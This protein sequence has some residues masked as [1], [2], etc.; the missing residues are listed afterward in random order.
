MKKALLFILGIV[1]CQYICAAMYMTGSA[2]GSTSIDKAIQMTA[3]GCTYTWFGTLKKGTLNFIT[4]KSESAS[5]YVATE[6]KESVELNKRM[7][8]DYSST[9][10]T[11]A[12]SFSAGEYTLV[13]DA[14]NN[15]LLVT[16][17]PGQ[18]GG[19]TTSPSLYLI[20][21]STSAGWNNDQ[22][23]MMDNN[24]DTYTY[25]GTFKN[26]ELKFLTKLGSW[27]PCYVATSAN[28]KVTV[29]TTYNLAYRNGD[30]GAADNKFIMPAGEYTITITL[31]AA[32]HKGTMV[33]TSGDTPID[34]DEPDDPDK[35]DYPTTGLQIVG[36]FSEWK[37]IA[38]T[39]LGGGIYTY[40]GNFDA[41][42]DF[43]FRWADGWW[44]G[45]VADASGNVEMKDGQTYKMK[46]YETEP[47]GTADN[48]W[49]FSTSGQK[50]IYVDLNKQETGT[51]IPTSTDNEVKDE[52]SVYASNNRIYISNLQKKQSYVLMNAI[53]VISQGT[54][55]A[56]DS[57]IGV[58]SFGLYMLTIGDESYKLIVK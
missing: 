41:N 25:K 17:T 28:Q 43:K 1:F 36:L 10:S 34:P 49:Y 18:G 39:D 23:I 51:S 8:V 52:L 29:G 4:D 38:M 2:T 26:D 45:L 16:G 50:T 35:P 33:V 54:L 47:A 7:S 3:D 21:P 24:E 48:K 30:S 46:Y 42:E 55:D 11:N 57:S 9:A 12:F 58:P 31:D 27:D 40:T 37:P 22:A 20:G 6:A 13:L 15:T 5:Y 32:N 19:S 14:T 56:G 44:P 53:K